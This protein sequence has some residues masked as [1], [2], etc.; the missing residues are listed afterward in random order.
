M[1]IQGEHGRGE[2]ISLH[3]KADSCNFI[4][5]YQV[6]REKQYEPSGGKIKERPGLFGWWKC[7]F[8]WFLSRRQFENIQKKH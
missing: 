8:V 5:K 7:D 2:N 3:L 4:K 6:K 1:C